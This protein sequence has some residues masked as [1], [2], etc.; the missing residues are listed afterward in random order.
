MAVKDTSEDRIHLRLRQ[1]QKA[2]LELAAELRHTTV[3]SFV[4]SQ[5][6]PSADKVIDESRQVLVSQ[7]GFERFLAELDAPA[8]EIPEVVE[9]MRRPYLLD[10]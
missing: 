1:D 2:R 10:D 7:E 9:L 8:R 4:L 3:T 6:L 5:V